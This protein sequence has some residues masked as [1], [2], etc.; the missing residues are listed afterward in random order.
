MEV[1]LFVERGMKTTHSSG[2]GKHSGAKNPQGQTRPIPTYQEL[3][4]ESLEGTF[5][6]SDPVAPG[7]AM[8][9]GKKVKTAKDDKDWKIEPKHAPKRASK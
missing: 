5:P 3:L 2:H 8:H 6:A 9:A 4:D 7:A 1:T